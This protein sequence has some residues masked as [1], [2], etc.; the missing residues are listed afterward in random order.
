M[1]MGIH[2]DETRWPFHVRAGKA[3]V[4]VTG[5]QGNPSLPPLTLDERFGCLPLR[6]Q[7]IEFL[8]HPSSVDLRV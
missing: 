4:I 1:S 7:R 2:A 6:V 8:L 3:P 5:R